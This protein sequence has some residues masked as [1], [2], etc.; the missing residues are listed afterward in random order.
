MHKTAQ[1]IRQKQPEITKFYPF[2]PPHR[3]IPPFLSR[4]LPH[5][6]TKWQV[7]PHDDSISH[8]ISMIVNNIALAEQNSYTLPGKHNLHAGFRDDV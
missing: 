3:E 4:C 2:D 8:P 5:V 1:K 7:A 6:S